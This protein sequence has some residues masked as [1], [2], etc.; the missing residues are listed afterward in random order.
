MPIIAKT[1][2]M[3]YFDI[4][5]VASSSVKELIW[6][7][8][9]GG[10]EVHR[11][12][13]MPG[14]ISRS[15]NQRSQVVD[16]HNGPEW[17]RT[18]PFDYKGKMPAHFLKFAIVRDPILRLHS[19]W[20]DKVNLRQI[21]LRQEEAKDLKDE[22]L[23]LDPSFG[24]FI[25]HFIQYRM[26]SRPARVHSTSYIWH[27]GPTLDFFDEVYRL[28]DLSG[29]LDLIQTRIKSGVA[30]ELARSNRGSYD[31]RNVNISAR[32]I[33]KLLEITVP[34]YELLGGLYRPEQAIRKLQE[35]V[36]T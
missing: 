29:L 30:L 11:L 36:V 12:R 14:L 6:R 4:T 18:K 5:K 25:D 17:L 28:E 26:I 32:Q 19:A 22:G 35:L 1:L 8:E 34:D 2:E 31:F 9:C 27:L 20:R 33:D 10:T 3:V 24:E 7:C 13:G 15:K 16:V 23:P 21:S